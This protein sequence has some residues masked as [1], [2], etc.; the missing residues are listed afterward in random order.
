[1]KKLNFKIVPP[2]ESDMFGLY[3]SPLKY[4]DKLDLL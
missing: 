4:Y 2:N 1:M 3:Y